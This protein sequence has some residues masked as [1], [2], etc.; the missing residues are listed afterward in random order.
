MITTVQCINERLELAKK[1]IV[2]AEIPALF[3]VDENKLIIL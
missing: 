3:Y 2:A 1:T